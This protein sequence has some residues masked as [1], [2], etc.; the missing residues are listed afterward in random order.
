MAKRTMRSAYVRVMTDLKTPLG[1]GSVV[2]DV[3]NVLLES[4][5]DASD[6]NF[7]KKRSAT[8]S[9]TTAMEHPMKVVCVHLEPNDPAT[10]DLPKQKALDAA[11]LGNNCV[12][13]HVNGELVSM[14]KHPKKK[15][16]MV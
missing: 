10:V 8:T 14:N 9:T 12:Q 5:H 13:L 16:A 11:D 6:S 1:K 7:P 2:Q 4:G 3:N 15:A